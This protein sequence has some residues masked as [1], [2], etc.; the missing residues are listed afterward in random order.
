[1]PHYSVWSFL[2]YS[3]ET[4]PV[5]IHHGAI[6]PVNLAGFLT[7]FGQMRSAIDGISIGTIQKEKW[8]GDDTLLSN[9]LPANAFAQR[10]L[11]WLVRYRD[12]TSNK[13]YNIEIPCADPTGRLV[14]GTDKADLTET[15]MAAFV[16][17]FESFGR[18]PE[19]D[20]HNVAVQEIILVGRNI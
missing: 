14:A 6:T 11:K 13:I 8:V 15:N 7:E 20:T 19:S 12:T 4:S 10:E 5:T 1:M 3:G 16:T 17:R 2:D 18:S 9:A